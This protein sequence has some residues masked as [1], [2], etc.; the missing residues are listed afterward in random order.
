[1]IARS[2]DG[3]PRCEGHGSYATLSAWR[4]LALF[5]IAAVFL[6]IALKP[7]GTLAHPFHFEAVERPCELRSA[8][9]VSSTVEGRCSLFMADGYLVFELNVE[10]D[11]GLD[12]G[13]MISGAFNLSQSTG[14]L[15][16]ANGGPLAGGR[17]RLAAQSEQIVHMEPGDLAVWE[18]GYSLR[19]TGPETQADDPY[20]TAIQANQPSTFSVFADY[21]EQGMIHI[22]PRGLDHILFV[23]GLFLLTPKLRPLLW[24]VSAF[25]LAHTVTLGLGVAGYINLPSSL[26]EPLIALSIAW[27]AIENIFTDQLQKWRLGIV[28]GFGLL[29]GLGFAGVLLDL[30]LS[31]THFYSALFGFNIGVELGQLSVIALCF[32]LFGSL[33]EKAYYRTRVVIPISCVIALIGGY[34]AWERLA[35]TLS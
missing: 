31:S 4:R 18:N 16:E 7:F 28:F 10:Q 12:G 14:T 26:I 29:H 5:V 27:V 6:F 22:V 35:L 17:V 13:S 9:S 24:Q 23:V 2:Q 3:V 20:W 25:T 21:V 19:L 15:F 8:G 32:I 30:G 11:G 1:M 33:M 34:W